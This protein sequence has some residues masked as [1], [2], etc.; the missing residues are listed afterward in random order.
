MLKVLQDKRM[1]MLL[2]ILAT[3]AFNFWTGSRY[4]SLDAKAMMAGSLEMEDGLSFDAT[5]EN[6][7]EA[8]GLTGWT[9][10]TAVTYVNW[11]FTNKQGMIFGMMFAI[12]LMSIV[13]LYKPYMSKKGGSFSSTMAGFLVGSPLGVC[14]NCAAPI[15]Y[16]LHQAGARVETALATMLSSPTMNIVVLTM[17]F[18]LFPVHVVAVKVVLTLC[19]IFV[20]VPLLV[21]IFPDEVRATQFSDESSGACE[22]PLQVQFPSIIES[23]RWVTLDII[24]NTWFLI[25]KVIPLMLLAGLLG[26]IAIVTLPWEQMVEMTSGFNSSRIMGIVGMAVIA[27]FGLF[28]PVPI[29]FDVIVAGI[30]YA[31][32]MPMKYVATL[33]FVLG[34]F[35]IYS[36]LVIRSTG[37]KKIANG[38]V[39]F[40]LAAGVLAGVATHYLEDTYQEQQQT[41]YFSLL[42]DEKAAR[43]EVTPPTPTILTEQAP[44]QNYVAM[45]DQPDISVLAMVASADAN[46]SWSMRKVEGGTGLQRHEKTLFH[47]SSFPWNEMHSVA[48]GDIN[49]DNWIDLAVGSTEGLF[50][51]TNIGGKFHL[52]EVAAFKGVTGVISGLA[53]VD[54]DNNGWLDL[55]YNVVQDKDYVAYNRAGKFEEPVALSSNPSL[56]MPAFAF[57]DFDQNGLLDMYLSKH[58]ALGWKFVSGDQSRNNILW[59]EGDGSF[60]NDI[61]KQIPGETL[62]AL[63]SDLN[64]DG[65]LDILAGNEFDSPDNYYFGEAGRS[66]RAWNKRGFET[67]DSSMSIDSADINN[68]LLLDTYHAQITRNPASGNNIIA[69]RSAD[70]HVSGVLCKGDKANSAECHV[71]RAQ[72]EASQESKDDASGCLDLQL[73]FIPDCLMAKIW[74]KGNRIDSGLID[75]LKN[76]PTE[77][78]FYKHLITAPID[79]RNAIEQYPDAMPQVKNRNLL[80]VRSADNSVKDEA[81]ERGVDLSAWSWNAKF[82]DLDGDQWQDLYVVNGWTPNKFETENVWF[83]NKKGKFKVATK[84]TD[85]GDFTPTGSY[86]Y[87]DYDNDGDLDV[88]TFNAEGYLNLYQNSGNT[89]NHLQVELRDQT[90]NRFGVGSRIIVRY[91][92]DLAQIREIKASGGF[93]S[94][95]AQVAHFGLGQWTDVKLI[96]VH[97]FNGEISYYEGPFTTGARYRIQ[98]REG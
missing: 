53:L 96:E 11:L 98:R 8:A 59:Q 28:L 71:A 19:L 41:D 46:G 25:R 57:G 14:V 60:S 12:L 93:L 18:S 13:T 43:H 78:A 42:L 48:S 77:Y 56:W 40:L 4:P 34:S 7:I 62:T 67:T 97:W 16:G 83:Q 63:V 89:N 51:Y 85:L 1:V 84:N 21:R 17:A 30:L 32:G 37:A 47:Y 92:D 73:E 82:A 68:D 9:A 87:I 2:L 65:N 80:Y 72:E 22:L 29:A 76:Y 20:A 35:S 61:L 79:K 10:K 6:T 5:I 55:V 88:I 36:Y 33:L 66:F 27:V 74:R 69:Q 70:S 94:F 15:A 49:G 38:L 45:H 23:A 31:S 75:F 39:V 58:N 24:K 26:S 91:G 50:V 81:A 3:L 64:Q 95:D 44:I 86:T 52:T 54:L 90:G